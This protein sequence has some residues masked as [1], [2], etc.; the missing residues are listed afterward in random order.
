MKKPQRE[1]TFV[2]LAA[3]VHRAASLEP[4]EDLSETYT[5]D[6]ADP[7]HALHADSMPAASMH[8]SRPSD[9]RGSVAPVGFHTGAT[10]R[11][12][13]QDTLLYD[14]DSERSAFSSWIRYAS[15]GAAST[16]FRPSRENAEGTDRSFMMR[17]TDTEAVGINKSP[18]V[19]SGAVAFEYQV[20]EPRTHG[21]HIYFAMIPMQQS[22]HGLLEVGADVPVN[23]RNKRSPYRNR[24]FV[25][26]DQYGDGRWHTGHMAFDFH[27]LPTA[28]YS[29]F[30]PR[31]NE[32]VDEPR[33]ATLP[34][35]SVRAWGA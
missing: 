28:S 27:G 33:A 25:P 30:A 24:V 6:H 22:Q 3:A 15:E 29:I 26:A 2:R 19:L 34:V 20:T 21:W 16:H 13:R 8:G 10:L 14:S 7:R 17:A 31:I 35:R 9:P 23:P 4:A 1:D 32:G 12:R 11:S 18:P 5:T